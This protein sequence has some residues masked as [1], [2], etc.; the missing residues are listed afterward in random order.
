MHDFDNTDVHD[1][2]RG[3]L[4]EAFGIFHEPDEK[5]A[6]QEYMSNKEP[7]EEAKKF[8]KLVDDLEQE[9]YPGCKKF[10][11]LSFI[12]RLF[13]LK[14]LNGWTNSSFTALLTLIKEALPDGETLPN[15][16]YEAKKII[17][18]LGLWYKI[19]DA[20]PNDCQLYYKGTAT[21]SSCNICGASRLD[22]V[23]NL[24][25]IEVNQNRSFVV[26]EVL[27]AL[28][29][30]VCKSD[31]RIYGDRTLIE[32]RSVLAKRPGAA[33]PAD[34]PPGFHHAPATFPADR[35][36]HRAP[37]PPGAAAAAPAVCCNPGRAWPSGVAAAA[38]AP[39][40]P[41][42]PL[43]DIPRARAPLPAGR[44]RPDAPP[45]PPRPAAAAQPEPRLLLFTVSFP[46]RRR[47]GPHP[48]SPS[49]LLPPSSAVP[50]LPRPPPWPEKPA[51]PELLSCGLGLLRRRRRRRFSSPTEVSRVFLTSPAPASGPRARRRAA[52]SRPE[53]GCSGQARNRTLFGVFVVLGFPSLPDLYGR[54]HDDPGKLLI[55]VLTLVS[56]GKA[57]FPCFGDVAPFQP[58]WL[59][60]RVCACFFGDLRLFRC[61]RSVWEFVMTA[62][63]IVHGPLAFAEIALPDPVS[64]PRLH[65]LAVPTGRGDMFTCSHL[66]HHFSGIA[67]DEFW[68]ET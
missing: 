21:A 35:R 13:H 47:L 14:C 64:T 41:G 58:F 34:P 28:V 46:R 38:S 32:E 12:V 57:P 31:R 45:S 59:L 36:R 52:G 44:R 30:S 68:D 9:L 10:S 8:Y 26:S 60:F 62:G 17:N 4:N 39:P 55:I 56:V 16:F 19:I 49:D 15:L 18:N 50:D 22:F 23:A 11:K 48:R 42:N 29:Q 66:P 43:A 40:P 5:I 51:E 54:E 53:Q 37:P 67:G 6:Q 33:P 2:I 25:S 65:R 1:D 20:C 24:W 3:M 61:L 7:N 63:L 27:I